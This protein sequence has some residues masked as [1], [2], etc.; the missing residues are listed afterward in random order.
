MLNDIPDRFPVQAIIAMSQVITEIANIGPVDIWKLAKGRIAFMETY[1]RFGYSLQAAFD[2]IFGPPIF[3]KLL[4]AYPLGI[5]VY[6]VY[7]V[8]DIFEPA[9]VAIRKCHAGLA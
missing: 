9:E 4:K 8:D 2:R 3:G 5:R 1:C 7:I 6:R